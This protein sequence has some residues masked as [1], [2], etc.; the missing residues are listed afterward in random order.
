MPKDTRERALRDGERDVA[1]RVPQTAQKSARLG[2]HRRPATARNGSLDG[3]AKRAGRANRKS[4]R[5]AR[6]EQASSES[7]REQTLAVVHH[8]YGIIVCS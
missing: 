4:E 8:D 7:G 3:P 2:N 1:Q 5:A 6:D